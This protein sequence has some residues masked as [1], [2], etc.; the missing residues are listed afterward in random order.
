MQTY[1]LGAWRRALVNLRRNDFVLLPF[2]VCPLLAHAEGHAHV[3]GIAKLDIDMEVTML[4]ILLDSPMDNLLGFERAPRTDVERKQADGVV[5]QLNAAAT[6]FKI[7]P[8]AQ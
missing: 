1:L 2:L 6:L 4:T 7:D 5:A 3:H 8:A